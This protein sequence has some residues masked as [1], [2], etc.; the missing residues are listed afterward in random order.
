MVKN[1]EAQLLSG[2]LDSDDEDQKNVTKANKKELER[3]R[4]EKKEY[5]KVM[6]KL[7]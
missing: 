1:Y 6:K 5:K 3:K 7:H 2:S 4:D